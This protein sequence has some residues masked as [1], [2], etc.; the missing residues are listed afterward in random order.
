MENTN[1]EDGPV[2]LTV[3]EAAR[4]LSMSNA[5]VY[6]LLDRQEV[7]SVYLGKKSRRVV[8]ASLDAYIRNLPITPPV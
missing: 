8:K 1:T 2:L 6:K 3:E 4:R 7:E 5:Y